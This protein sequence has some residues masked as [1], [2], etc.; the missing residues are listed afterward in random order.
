[1]ILARSTINVGGVP[2]GWVGWVD[3]TDPWVK[4]ALNAR[5]FVEVYFPKKDQDAE[6][7]NG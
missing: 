3:E 5:Y 6:A 1:M 4:R 2:A 7:P